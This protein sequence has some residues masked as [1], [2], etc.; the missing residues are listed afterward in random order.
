MPIIKTPYGEYN[1]K[2]IPLYP[3]VKQIDKNIANENLSL[4]KHILDSKSI[5]FQLHAGTLLGAVRDHDFISHDEDI[6]LA[7]LDCYRNEILKIIPLLKSEGFE[8]C[9]YDRRDLIS[10]MRKGEYIDLYFY[11]RYNDKFLSCSG[12]LVINT[13]IE[14]STN[15]EFKGNT[16]SIPE[17]WEQ[18]LEAEYGKDWKTPIQW[19]NY[20]M[21][22]YKRI[23]FTIKAYLKDYLPLPLFNYLSNKAEKKLIK[24]SLIRL[25]KN[26]NISIDNI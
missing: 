25:E 14:N 20:L 10:I 7:L 21:P 11:R 24:K 13:H 15:L 23:L 8:I 6:D 3:G 19:N 26:L 1:Y 2:T 18:Y 22:I 5:P 17:N 16:Y 9:R 4:L 12:W